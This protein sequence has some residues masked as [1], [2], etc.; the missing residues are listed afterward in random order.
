ME[1]GSVLKKVY[2]F[3]VRVGR[4]HCLFLFKR[5][6]P[7]SCANLGSDPCPQKCKISLFGYSLL[8]AR[9][10]VTVLVTLPGGKT[11]SWRIRPHGLHGSMI[12]SGNMGHGL[13]L[14]KSKPRYWRGTA[15]RRKSEFKGATRLPILELDLVKAI[16][17]Y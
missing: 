2:S 4:T 8:L 1:G 6:G 15:T 9:F 5:P 13:S 17:H 11:F 10:A 16:S 14:R 7:A 12:L 3:Y